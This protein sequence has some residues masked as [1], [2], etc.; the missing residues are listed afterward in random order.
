MSH[1][2]STADNPVGGGMG[3]GRQRR[4]RREAKTLSTRDQI[5]FFRSLICTGARRNPAAC[6]HKLGQLKKTLC[7]QS[8]GWWG[9]TGSSMSSSKR[10]AETGRTARSSAPPNYT[11]I[12]M[13]YNY[14]KYL[15]TY[16]YVYIYIYMYMYMYMYI[17]T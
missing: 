4:R 17:Y 11:H 9:G 7:P 15:Y 5:A 8:G 10:D 16:T 1:V 2:R 13:I 14:F 3:P 12:Y 6:G